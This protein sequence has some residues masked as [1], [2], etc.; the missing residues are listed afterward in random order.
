MKKIELSG[1]SY[2]ALSRHSLANLISNTVESNSEQVCLASINM[3]ALAVL[4][5]EPLFNKYYEQ[6]NY[7]YL[8]GMPIIW[9]LKLL[10]VEIDSNYRITVLDWHEDFFELANEKN[11]TVAMLGGKKSVVIKACDRLSAQFENVTFLSHHGYIDNKEVPEFLISNEV[12]VL[13]VGMGMP[14][15]EIWILNNR[16]K[17][18]AKVIIPV[19]GYFDYVAGETYTPPRWSG[20]LGLEWLFRLVSSP[21]RLARRYLVE[22]WPV[23]LDFLKEL[24]SKSIERN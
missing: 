9:M 12:D 21:K 6:T 19:G 23:M 20:R 4:R 18:N 13:L 22:P 14:K 1:K 11:F 2:T 5:R 3:H 17:L 16:S 15:E 10:G 24:K 7:I 8:D